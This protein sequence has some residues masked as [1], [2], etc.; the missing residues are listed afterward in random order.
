M[1][2]AKT[3]CLFQGHR[4]FGKAEEP[5]YGN[6]LRVSFPTRRRNTGF[7]QPDHDR[8]KGEDGHV[9]PEIGEDERIP[10]QSTVATSSAGGVQATLP[11]VG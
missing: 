1:R 11:K 8:N 7:F 5:P 4:Q 6:W 2:H 9:Q 3:W 10:Y